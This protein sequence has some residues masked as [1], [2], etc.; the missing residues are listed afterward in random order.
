LI[1]ARGSIDA[2]RYPKNLANL[3]AALQSLGGA[4][5]DVVSEERIWKQEGAAGTEGTNAFFIFVSALASLAALYVGVTGIL[6]G[7][8]TL[9]SRRYGL[10]LEFD[11]PSAQ[12]ASLGM[13][14]F[15]LNLAFTVYMAAAHKT[16]LGN[17]KRL[18]NLGWL[19]SVGLIV[20]AALISN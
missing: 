16:L 8:F 17:S 14:V 7:H 12:I 9:E 10:D 1:E 18:A 2:K 13:I 15:G 5:D 6:G 20:A 4:P 3:E 19:A 11:G